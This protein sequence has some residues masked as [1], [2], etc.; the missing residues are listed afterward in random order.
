MGADSS[1][2]GAIRI[3]LDKY[4]YI[5]GESI[6]GS[7]NVQVNEPIPPCRIQFGFKGVEEVKWSETRGAGKHRRTVH[8]Y[9]KFLISRSKYII[10]SWNTP[11]Q[12]GSFSIPIVFVTPQ[13]LPGSFQFLGHRG[14][15]LVVYKLY[16]RLFSDNIKLKDKQGVGIYND[17][18]I[19]RI[20]Q[21]PVTAN[22][23]AWCCLNKGQVILDLQYKND[24]YSLGNPIQCAL[25][26]DNSNSKAKVKSITAH[27]YFVTIPTSGGGF[28]RHFPT[29]VFKSTYQ[30]SVEKGEK[31]VG[32]KASEFSF[33]LD[34]ASKQI[35]FMSVHTMK[36]NILECN[37]YLEFELN[38][39]I[40][41]LCCG[42]YP[43]ITSSIYVRP[44]ANFAAPLIV[45]PA[46]WQP[47]MY[48]PVQLYYNPSNEA[49][50]KGETQFMQQHKGDNSVLNQTKL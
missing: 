43:K 46:N 35:D 6:R 7:I 8:F 40:H 2:Y 41:C 44:Q 18:P 30:I 1:K 39:N 26:I 42:D 24:T 25:N 34:D 28:T 29:T 37:F 10:M 48:E 9:N 19:N 50:D 5:S 27:V 12:P 4:V 45:K 20:Y 3:V 15:F 16:I 33:S 17:I 32:D 31:L 47:Q 49:G 38:M 36:G 14:I 23:I 21:G 13:G 11:L 22:L